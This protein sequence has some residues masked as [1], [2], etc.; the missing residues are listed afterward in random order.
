MAVRFFP[1]VLLQYS[2]A[3]GLCKCQY[4]YVAM[5]L[6]LDCLCCSLSVAYAMQPAAA[7]WCACFCFFSKLSSQS[8]PKTATEFASSCHDDHHF[9]CEDLSMFRTGLP[10]T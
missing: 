3:E 1:G 8:C 9:G 10:C 5:W 4:A 2:L 7:Q 6:Q